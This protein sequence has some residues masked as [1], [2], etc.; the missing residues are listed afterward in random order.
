[1]LALASSGQAVGELH[2]TQRRG[3]PH[4]YRHHEPHHQGQRPHHEVQ[5]QHHQVQ[6]QG[7]ARSAS[8]TARSAKNTAKRTTKRTASNAST[9]TRR[10]ARKAEQGVVRHGRR[11]VEAAQAEVSAVAS[12]P[13][14]P[15][16]FT[17]GVVDRAASS[18]KALPGTLT[19]TVISAPVRTRGRIVN[20]FATAGDLAEKAQRGYTEVAK[21]GEKFVRAVRRQE[22]TQKA[23]RYADRAQTRTSRAVSDAEKAVEFG[24]EAAGQ[25]V[26]KLG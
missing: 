20:V 25:A 22:S 8:T 17:L 23:V 12:Q 4:G 6:R 24:T 18:V 13:T 1:V 9:T 10:E 14:R 21:D 11:V 7:T 3:D 16:F 5:R 15:L 26:A 2:C 19:S